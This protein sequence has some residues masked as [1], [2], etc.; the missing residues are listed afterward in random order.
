MLKWQVAL[1][2]K[3]VGAD[4]SPVILHSCINLPNY[5]IALPSVYK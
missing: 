5:W 2:E 4:P 3:D 1:F